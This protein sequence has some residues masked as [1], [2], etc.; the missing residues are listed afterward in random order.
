M[1]NSSPSGIPE[2]N[3]DDVVKTEVIAH[4]RFKSD[5]SAARYVALQVL[6]EFDSV[7]HQIGDVLNHQLALRELNLDELDIEA[8]SPKA[9][10]ILNRLV[11]AVAEN[12]DGL[13]A[14]IQHYAQEWPL[15]QVAIV[16]RNILRMAVCEFAILERVMPAI[17]ID[18]AVRLAKWFGSDGTPR[19]V[20]G[21][22]GAIAND[23]DQVKSLLSEKQVNKDSE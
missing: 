4:E 15:N 13:D 9:A 21:V 2:F 14:V 10:R 8:L 6:Y 5:R 1:D 7:G 17:A 20:N 3:S 11:M 18:E 22:L 12:R 16:D 23:L 19:F